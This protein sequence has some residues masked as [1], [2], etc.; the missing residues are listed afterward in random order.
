MY[1]PRTW[2]QPWTVTCL[3]SQADAAGSALLAE[4]DKEA[5]TTAAML[6]NNAV[7]GDLYV[8]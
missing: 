5:A 8:T 3:D 4:L 1:N 7:W 2:R 6:V